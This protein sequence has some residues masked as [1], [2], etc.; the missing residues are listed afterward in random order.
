[1]SA[2]FAPKTTFASWP[3]SK[4]IWQHANAAATFL[5]LHSDANIVTAGRLWGSS[6]NRS[7]AGTREPCRRWTLHSS[8]RIRLQRR[9]LRLERGI[10][11]LVLFTFQGAV[12][13]NSDLSQCNVARVR[14][15]G[16]MFDNSGSSEVAVFDSAIG[17]WNVDFRRPTVLNPL[18]SIGTSR[19]GSWRASLPWKAPFSRTL[20]STRT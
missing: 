11:H 12:G 10:C 1:M 8:M 18:R 9:P 20:P 19:S 16:W 6:R 15:L 3:P 4:P 13:F 5:G 17:S 7:A 2:G 14:D